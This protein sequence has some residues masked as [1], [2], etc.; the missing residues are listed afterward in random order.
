MDLQQMKAKFAGKHVKFTGMFSNVDGP[1]A[2]VWRVT[3]HGVWVTM[4]DGSRQ[5]W[6]PESITVVPAPNV[7]A[8]R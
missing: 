6:H 1:T 4:P 3:R 5:Q 8:P 7:R 2:K